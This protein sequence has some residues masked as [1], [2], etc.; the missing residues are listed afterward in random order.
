MEKT[1]L[2]RLAQE[3]TLSIYEIR[4]LLSLLS[5]ADFLALVFSLLIFVTM[6]LPWVSKA[7]SFT[8]TGLMG[9]GIVHLLLAIYTLHR[10]LKAAH[11]QLDL[12]DDGF[13]PMRLKR[14][15]LSYLLVGLLSTLSAIFHLIYFSQQGGNLD[16]RAGFYLTSFLGLGIFCCGL[17]RFRS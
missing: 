9:G 15:S 6:F 2:D 1:L 3:I 7:D 12:T 17:E 13:L 14:I 16:L 10:A 11:Y 5:K 4:Y 8:I